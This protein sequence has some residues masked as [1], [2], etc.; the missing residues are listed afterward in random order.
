M[1]HMPFSYVLTVQDK[2]EREEMMLYTY[3][4]TKVNKTTYV[5]I[6]LPKPPRQDMIGI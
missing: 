5:Y 4:H 1:L 6:V 3:L 2:Q